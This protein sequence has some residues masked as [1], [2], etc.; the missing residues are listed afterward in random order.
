M[1]DLFTYNVIDLRLFG[2]IYLYL[3]DSKNLLPQEKIPAAWYGPLIV[4]GIASCFSLA[5]GPV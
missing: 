2:I 1:I 4:T 5:W 3:H